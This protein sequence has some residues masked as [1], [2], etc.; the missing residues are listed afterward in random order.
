M[1]EE[2]LEVSSTYADFDELWGTLLLGVGPVGA[3]VIAQDQTRRNA[4]RSALFERLGAPNGQFA[5]GAVARAVVG[6]VP[7]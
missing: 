1:Q 6:V 4:I 2:R 7:G 5:L 3:Y